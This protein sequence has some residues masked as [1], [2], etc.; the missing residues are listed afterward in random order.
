MAAA[1]VARPVGPRVAARPAPPSVLRVSSPVLQRC[2]GHACPPS[3]C[4]HDDEQPGVLRR[5]RGWGSEPSAVP[6]VVH[7]VLRSGGSP[8]DGG[9]RANMEARFGHDFGQVRIHTDAQAAASASAVNALA[10]TVGR[11]VVFAAGQYAPASTAGQAL[12]AHELTHVVQQD[13]NGS[14]ENLVL[15]DMSAPEERQADT[16]AGGLAAG[17]APVASAASPG[18]VRRFSKAEHE[19][20][21]ADAYAESMPRAGNSTE[22]RIDEALLG[23]LR[24]F[25]YERANG[26]PLSYAQLVAAADE[27][28]SLSEMERR[29]RERA[30]GGV[31]GTIWGWMGDTSHYVD[32]AAKNLQHFHPHNYMAWQAWQWTALRKMHEA[33]AL[34][35]QSD[36]LAGEKVVILQRFDAVTAR[37]RGL[38]GELDRTTDGARRERLDREIAAGT[39]MMQSLLARAQAKQAEAAA[40]RAAGIQSALRAVT[41]NGF[42]N[43]FLTDAFAAGHIITPRSD[44]LRDYATYL[45]GIV[46]VGGVL[47][48]ANVPS[49]AWHDLDN[50]FGV[51]V[52]SIEDQAGWTTYGDEFAATQDPSAAPANRGRSDTLDHVITATRTSIQQLW[53]TAATGQL[54]GSLGPV[55]NKLP[56]PTFEGY[57]RWNAAEWNRQLRSAAGELVGADY[58]LPGE[59]GQGPNEPRAP[60]QQGNQIGL[61]PPISARAT[62]TNVISFFTWDAFVLPMIDRA[63]REYA[64]RFYTAGPGQQVDP[65]AVPVAQPSA[66]GSGKAVA[67]AVIGGLGLGAAGAIIGFLAG[68]PIGAL[69]G[70]LIGLIG[71]AIGGGIIG[72][73]LGSN[74]RADEPAVNPGD[75][76]G[77]KAQ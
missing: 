41:I 52:N 69:V 36:A 25:R 70:G 31:L 47:N 21:G 62:C 6:P 1:P 35:A 67:G 60:N 3:G 74:R 7:D 42:G 39:G 19:Q 40:A 24:T 12:V 5:Q 43:H 68:G 34:L 26:Q 72:G 15:G 44:L 33:H 32:L 20:I 57:P 58:R 2:A 75:V 65:N 14:A 9:M 63:K 38:F 29:D 61:I 46:R 28:A 66:A 22:P 37:L 23:R 16:F 13:G 49:L 64:Q 50:F 73:L 8:L 10:Y 11:D 54:P 48:C 27:F 56:R 59:Q 76:A 77:G 71:G 53:Q 51:R 55:L 4:S 18:T 17:G 30:G 45:L